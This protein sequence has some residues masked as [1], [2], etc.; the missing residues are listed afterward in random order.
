VPTA[1]QPRR[2]SVTPI[3]D[4][5]RAPLFA[6]LMLN[7]VVLT[8]AVKTDSL[9][10]WNDVDLVR[11]WRSFLP[12]G[13]GVVFAGVVNGLLS[14]DNKARLAFWR[15]SNPLPGSF[16]FSRYA[17]RDPRIDLSA[18]QKRVG[19]FPSEPRD[20]NS[21]WYRLYKS[22]EAEPAVTDAHRSFLLTRD[23]TAVAFLLLL[24]AGP[25]S[26]IF[27]TS[28]TTAF[29]YISLLL[30]QYLLARQAASNYGVRFVTSVLALKAS[31]K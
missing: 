27:I 2:T 7:F 26:I 22:V 25:L 5:N 6:V 13:V 20:Q 18:L 16:A 30:L 4:H 11:Q 9:L 15:W 10:A 23:Y 12:A 19:P 17:Q 24:A 21:K 8:L 3:K 14:P 28:A 1:S 31:G 29:A